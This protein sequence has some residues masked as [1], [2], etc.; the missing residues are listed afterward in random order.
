MVGEDGLE[1]INDMFHENSML[2]IENN[3]LRMRVKAMQETIDAQGARLTQLLCEQA[4][5]VLSRAGTAYSAASFHLLFVLPL[6]I[7]T[8]MQVLVVFQ[9]KVVRKLEI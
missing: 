3:N 9:V 2:Q 4:N 8:Y 1:S 5:Q 6:S 7:P